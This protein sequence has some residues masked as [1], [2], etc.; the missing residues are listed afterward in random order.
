M[1]SD[2]GLKP[3]VNDLLAVGLTLWLEMVIA[4]KVHRLSNNRSCIKWG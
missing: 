4:V 1:A 3:I 2:D